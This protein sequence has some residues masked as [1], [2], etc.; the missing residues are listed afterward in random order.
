MRILFALI[1]TALVVA[2]ITLGSAF[3]SFLD[4][5]SALLVLGLTVCVPLANFSIREVMDAIG[6]A[7]GSGPIA[8][9]ETRQ[10]TSVLQTIR[11]AAAGSGIIGTFI[12]LIQMLSHM[13]NPSKIGPAMAVALL[14]FLY[15]VSISEMVIGP[16]INR[17]QRR[18]VATGDDSGKTASPHTALHVTG[19]LSCLFA[20]SIMLASF[21]FV[22]KDSAE[23]TEPGQPSAAEVSEETPTP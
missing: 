9:E 2:A 11:M 14:T 13:E 1:G 3:Q 5:P 17:L 16:W 6:A 4:A 15:G 23:A 19:I 10:H 12:G 22:E 8:A 21:S 18:T 20:F 7:L